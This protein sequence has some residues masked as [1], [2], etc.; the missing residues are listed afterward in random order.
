MAKTTSISLGDHFTG[1]IEAQVES[2]RFGSASEVVRA[3]LRSLEE[4]ELKHQ[5]LQRAITDGL[6]SGVAE[7]FSMD[8]LQQD[9][10]D[11]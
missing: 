7:E 9:M 6:S 2:G 8:A 5:A 4:R 1:F 10:D 3:G 11:E